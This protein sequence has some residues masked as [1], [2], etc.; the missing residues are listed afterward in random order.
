M[1]SYVAWAKNAENGNPIKLGTLGVGKVEFK[2]K[3]TFSSIFV[4]KET[5]P[6]TRSPKGAVIMQG[7]LQKISLL[8]DPSQ[9]EYKSELGQPEI[10]PTPK[11][12]KSSG[13]N[14]FRLGGTLA[15]VALIGII[16]GVF[17]LIK[18]R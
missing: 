16:A 2:T 7:G 6:S 11:V 8:E 1:F 4:T 14:I 12:Q 9:A 17:F 5:N 15:V 13:L 18:T 3:T 10:T